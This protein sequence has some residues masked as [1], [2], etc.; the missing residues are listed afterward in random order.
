MQ[1]HPLSI[2]LLLLLL[3]NVRLTQTQIRFVSRPGKVATF[4]LRRATERSCASVHLRRYD[5]V[6]VQTLLTESSWFALNRS[7]VIRYVCHDKCLC[8][9]PLR[10]QRDLT[11]TSYK[12]TG[13]SAAGVHR[14]NRTKPGAGSALDSRARFL[15]AAD[16]ARV[17]SKLQSLWL[18]GDTRQSGHYSYQPRRASIDLEATA[19]VWLHQM[20]QLRPSL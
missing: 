11:I 15:R 10:S 1:H 13:V 6:L 2:C 4:S 17:A 16:S 20:A 12:Q 8:C 9:A 18:V 3:L 7:R 14:T 19:H 5:S